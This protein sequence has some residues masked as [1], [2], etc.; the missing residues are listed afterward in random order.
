[1]AKKAIGIDLGTGFSAVAVIEGGKPV[2]ITNAEGSRTTPSVVSLK[3]GER[4]VGET[5]RR[6]RVVNPKETITTIKRFMGVEFDKCDE[7]IKNAPYEV[8]NSNGKPR[9]KVEGREYS[10]EEISSFII[11]KMKQTAEDYLGEKVEDAVITVP[12]WFDNAARESTKLAGEMCGLNVLRVI[13]EPTAAIL[14][15]EIDVKNGEKKVLVADIGSGTTDFSVC[16]LSEGITEVLASHGDVFL[17]GT[18]FDNAIANWIIEQFKEE[19]KVDLKED[20][21]ALQRILE[22]AEKAKIELSSTTSTEINL[23]YITAIEGQPVHLVKTLTKAKFEQLTSHLVDK[24]IACGVEAM[25]QAKVKNNELECVLLV[26]G[27]T[28]STAIQEALSKEF[29]VALNKSVNPDEAVAIGAA[30]QANTL[31]GGEGAGEMLLLDVTPLTLGIETM[32]GVMTPLVEANTTIPTKKTQIFSTAVDN[33]PAVTINVLQG[34]RPLARDN[35]SIGLFNLDGIAP[36]RRGIPQIEVTF[37]IDANG[38]VTVSAM[39]KATNKEQHITIE[40]KNSLSQEEI[41]RIKRE[42][43]EH[44]EEDKKTKEKLETANKC[45]SLIYSTERMIE[46][47]KEHVTEDDKTFF[48]EKMDKLKEMKEKDDYTGFDEI[49]KEVEARWYGISAKAYSQGQGAQDG[50][51]PFANGFNADDLFKSGA[52]TGAA[53]AE[54]PQPEQ[55]KQEDE[56]VEV[57]DVE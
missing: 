11:Q 34:E 12:A 6:Q 42:A 27:Q 1:M 37:D 45:E 24:I 48:N 7:L 16:E 36:A 32:G 55:P 23:P 29:G 5:A 49:E 15:S 50:A 54:Q 4:K 43:E 25:K 9:V 20:S 40:N 56:N 3:D 33:Q 41:D 14:A 35:K 47:M 38:I 17:G 44:A 18:D 39:D 13:N 2:V 53:G 31:V 52:F 30:I 8:V 19:N 22:A 28:R 21:Q 10:P 46:D 57:Q 51:N 26:G